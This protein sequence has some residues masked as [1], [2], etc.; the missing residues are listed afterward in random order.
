MYKRKKRKL[1]AAV[2]LGSLL[3]MGALGGVCGA[4]G[5]AS[6][7]VTMPKVMENGKTIDVYYRKGLSPKAARARG[8]VFKTESMILKAGT[9]RMP[10]AKPLSCDILFE[11]DVPVTLRDGTVIYTDIFRPVDE[12]KHPA[13]MA[14]SPY[15]KE[16]GGQWLDDVL[17]RSG[18]P[19]DAVSGL[20]PNLKYLVS[21]C[22]FFTPK[23]L[24]RH[25][26]PQN[27]AARSKR[28]SALRSMGSSS[29]STMERRMRG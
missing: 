3:A 16:I 28:R 27:S 17:G 2:C 5:N 11:K 23:K 24:T 12:A 25:S 15:G 13:I 20:Q 9:V 19:V 6:T 8:G 10:G 29:Q 4:E 26:S 18:V 7:V 14:W 22:Y 21:C 1:K